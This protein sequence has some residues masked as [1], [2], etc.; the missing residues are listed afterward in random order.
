MWREKK[1]L[2]RKRCIQRVEGKEKNER[3]ERDRV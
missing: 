3:S 2:L 1:T